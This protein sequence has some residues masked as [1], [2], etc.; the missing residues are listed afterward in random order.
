MAPRVNLRSAA[1]HGW[2]RPARATPSCDGKWSPSWRSPRRRPPWAWPRPPGF[3][4]Q[5]RWRS[6]RG[7]DSGTTRSW[8]RWEPVAWA[9]SIGLATCGSGARWPSRRSRAPFTADP[10]RR[11]RVRAEARVAGGALPSQHRHDSRIRRRRRRERA[12]HGTRR[13]RHARRAHLTNGPR[14]TSRAGDGDRPADC[15][16]ARRRAR[17]GRRPSRPETSQRQHHA[18]RAS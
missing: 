6:S 7:S 4:M 11:A 14:P 10:D 3:L 1:G 16:G 9:R 2:P 5:P 13:G 15:R 18:R 8:R 12:G 17:Q